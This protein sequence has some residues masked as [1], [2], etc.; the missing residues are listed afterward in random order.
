MLLDELV[1]TQRDF[2]TTW[3]DEA[4]AW[5]RNAD[6]AL[7]VVAEMLRGGGDKVRG[8]WYAW[9]SEQRGY[10]NGFADRISPKAWS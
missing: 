1:D 8:V 7:A 2:D 9:D 10:A 3:A 5:L 6:S 4:N